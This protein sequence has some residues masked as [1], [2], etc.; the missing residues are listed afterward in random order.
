MYMHP[1]QNTNTSV[2]TSLSDELLRE[3]FNLSRATRDDL[4][5]ASLQRFLRAKVRDNFEGYVLAGFN[6]EFNNE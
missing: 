5:P 6:E 1:I 3:G 4:P 2:V